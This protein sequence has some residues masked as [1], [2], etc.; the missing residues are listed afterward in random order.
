M[1]QESITSFQISKYITSLVS[2]YFTFKSL[3]LASSEAPRELR[4]Y[5]AIQIRLLLLLLLLFFF[6]DPGTQLL[7]LF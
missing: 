3:I 1:R 5:G 2:T 4:P 6:F 7:L